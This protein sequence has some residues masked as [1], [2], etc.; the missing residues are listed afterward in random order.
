MIGVGLLRISHVHA[1]LV[2]MNVSD[3]VF[4]ES[5]YFSGLTFHIFSESTIGRTG[6][7]YCPGKQMAV[8]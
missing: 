8:L 6:S 5:T 3:V 1:Q 7:F 4:M 2:Y